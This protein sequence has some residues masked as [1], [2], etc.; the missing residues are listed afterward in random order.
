MTSATK[1]RKATN[2]KRKATN[3][4]RKEEQQAL[5]EQIQALEQHLA[6]LKAH[7]DGG[8]SQLKELYESVAVNEAMKTVVDQ[9][10]L[11]VANAQSLVSQWLQSHSRNPMGSCIHLGREWTERR[12]TLLGM[13]DER[14]ARGFRYVIARCQHLDALKPHFSEEKFE[15]ANGDFCCVRNEVI[16]FPGVQSMRKV[17]DA[18]KFT[19]DT[20]EISISEQL[21]HITVRDDYDAVEADSFTCNY[22]LTSGID[23]GVT[24]ELNA[25]AFGRYVEKPAAVSKEPYAVMAIDSVDQDDLHPYHPRESVRK[26]LNGTVVLVAVPRRQHGVKKEAEEQGNTEVEVVMLRSFFVKTCRPEFE[27]SEAV[28]QELRNNTTRWGEVVLEAVRR[29]VYAS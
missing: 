5:Q 29:I 16:P 25:V 28:I 9:H 8:A 2:V 26:V 7:Q 19:L 23:S 11:A 17:F 15:D 21:G 20:L 14:L 12:E 6:A 1:K 22:R 10:Q 4:K 13:K 24:T 3:V 18:V 27:V